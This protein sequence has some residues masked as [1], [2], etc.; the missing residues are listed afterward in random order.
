[1]TN[2]PNFMSNPEMSATKNLAGAAVGQTGPTSQAVLGRRSLKQ[3]FV[4]FNPTGK[5][6]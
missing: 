5:P 2:N 1:M 6:G 3:A 4:T